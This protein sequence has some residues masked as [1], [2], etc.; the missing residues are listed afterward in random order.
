MAAGQL[1]VVGRGGL[2]VR[3]HGSSYILKEGLVHSTSGCVGGARTARLLLWGQACVIMV[4]ISYR[5]S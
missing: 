4:Q 2:Q 5:G 1:F 3:V